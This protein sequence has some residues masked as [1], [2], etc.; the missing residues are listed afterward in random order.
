MIMKTTTILLM[1]AA[2]A[3][4]AACS[5]DDGDDLANHRR[6]LTINVAEKP[7]VN[8]DGSR[9]TRGEIL[10]TSSTSFNAFTMDYVYGSTH[11]HGNATATKITPK[12]WTSEVDLGDGDNVMVYWYA[13]THPIND[14]DFHLTDDAS[15]LP[16]INFQVDETVAFQKDL[17]VATAADT[18]ANCYGGRLSFTFDHAC[19]ALRFYMKKAKNLSDYTLTVSEVKLCHVVE[20]GDY[21]FSTASWSLG[22]ETTD[23]TLFT[24]FNGSKTLG[25][26]N[27]E[28]MDTNESMAYL[29]LIPQTLTKWSGSGLPANTDTYIELNCTIKSGETE[30]HS[31]NAY[32][33]FG[34]TLEKGTQY[35]VNLNIGKNS[36]YKIDTNNNV[37][38]K[39]IN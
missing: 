19:A 17:L 30:I 4:A 14:Y 15:K 37:V 12:T 7:F 22:T 5:N 28:A 26:T 9:S 18:R 32:I 3:M 36:L 10:T 20:K 27:Y 31:G 24:L 33:P 11:R 21:F 2:L 13:H 35:D 16:Y 6:P 29:F 38:T 23:Y 8:P 25:D 39:I 34:A 1:A